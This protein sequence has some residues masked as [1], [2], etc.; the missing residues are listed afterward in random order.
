VKSSLREVAVRAGVSDATVSR[1]LN[2]VDARIAPETRRRV[3]HAAAEMGYQPNR[4]ARALATGRTQTLALWTSNLRSAHSAHVV[5]ET[6]EET[7]RHDYDLM[8]C[9]YQFRQDGILDTSRLLSWPVD[10]ILTVDLPRG[11]IPGLDGHLLGGKPFV[12][13]GAYVLGQSDYVRI[14]FS[15]VAI[16]AVRHLHEIG[17]RRIGYV[18]PDWFDW[19]RECGDARFLAYESVM[20]EIGQ[21][22]E[23]IVTTHETRGVVGPALK[24]H[25]AQHGCPDGLFCFNDDMAIG[26]FRALRDLGLRI[27]DDVA[28]VGCDGIDDAAYLDPSLTT[29]T[30]PTAEMCATAWSFLMRRIREPEMPLQQITLQPRLEVR[31]SSER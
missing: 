3:Q 9:A 23:Y 1:V 30:Q 20:A 17:C 21:K 11:D 19:F 26:A 8:I 2:S 27:P 22:P 4:T 16:E 12:N 7:L 18:L 6:R 31:G 14:D 25:V 29:I 5:Y 10:G 15:Q 13:M 24:T 28:L